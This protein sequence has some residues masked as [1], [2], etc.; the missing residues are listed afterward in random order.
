MLGAPAARAQSSEAAPTTTTRPSAQTLSTSDLAR[1]A[2]NAISKGV[3]YLLSQQSDNGGWVRR[4]TDG[5][6][7]GPTALVTLALLSCGEDPQNPPMVEAVKL[8]KR[9]RGQE[10]DKATYSVGLRASVFAVLPGASRGPELKGDLAWLESNM[11]PGV[12][13]GLYNYGSHGQGDYSNS[14]YGVLG[15]WAAAEA[16]LEVPLSYWRTVENAWLRGQHAD[17]GWG[18]T[19]PW[20]PFISLTTICTRETIR[21][22]SVRSSTSPSLPGWSGWPTI[23]RPIPTPVFTG[24]AAASMKAGI[25]PIHGSITCFS[26][27]SASARPPG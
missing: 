9:V 17:G 3:R 23:S 8:L 2:N 10:T 11:L 5:W 7:I 22:W 13:S 19:P 20:R 14:Q 12:R 27:M 16:G 6:G 24:L 18:Y 21:I 25:P 4:P 1:R 26:G 15:V